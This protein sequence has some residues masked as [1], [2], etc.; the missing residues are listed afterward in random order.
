MMMDLSGASRIPVT[1][2]FGRS[3]AGLNSTGEG[4]LENYADFIEQECEAK[5]RP[6]FQKFLPFICI[7][8]WGYV[9]QDAKIK[10]DPFRE[11]S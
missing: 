6:I 7:S 1:K 8:V 10:F 2:L 3:P 9:P 11:A 5:L 4:D